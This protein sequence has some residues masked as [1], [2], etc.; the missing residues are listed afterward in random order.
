MSKDIIGSDVNNPAISGDQRRVTATDHDQGDG[1]FKRSLDVSVIPTGGQAVNP[2]ASFVERA[3]PSS[4]IETYS[5]YESS[6]KVTLYNT[7]TVTYT[8][9][10]LGVLLSAEWS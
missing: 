7:I 8:D 10:T 2:L 5:Y 6:S 1:T 9:A 4:T 3:L